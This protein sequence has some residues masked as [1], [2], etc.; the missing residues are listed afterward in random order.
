[1]SL[2]ERLQKLFSI[3]LLFCS[4]HESQPDLAKVNDPNMF[5]EV[6]KASAHHFGRINRKNPVSKKAFVC[7]VFVN[8]VFHARRLVFIMHLSVKMLP[9][10]KLLK[11]DRLNGSVVYGANS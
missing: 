9:L 4:R 10:F 3:L 11:D 6:F 1:M 8:L 2:N 7:L 5:S